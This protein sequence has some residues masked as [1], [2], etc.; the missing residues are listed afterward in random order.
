MALFGKNKNK[1]EKAKK[2]LR[3]VEVGEITKEKTKDNVSGSAA[4]SGLSSS[5]THK[6][7]KGFYVS[8]KASL[9]TGMNQYVFKIFNGAN[10]SEVKKEVTRLFNVKVKNV[11]MLNM[12]EKRRDFGK[13][14]GSKSGFKK[15]IV[16]LKEGYVIGQAKP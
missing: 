8:E 10:K 14:P 1:K 6:V 4:F 11:R 9:G 2:E 15:A 3:D 13:H 5:Q 12:P 7:L 16:A